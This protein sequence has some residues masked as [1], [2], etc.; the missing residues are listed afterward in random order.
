MRKSEKILALHPTQFAIGML[1]VD[2]K[3]AI[4]EKYSRGELRKWVKENPVPVVISPQGEPFIVD[5]HHFLTVCY[6]LGLKKVKVEVVKDLSR[7]KMSYADFWKWMFKNRSAYPFCQFGE[8]PRKALYLPHDIRGLADDPYRSLAWFVRK[9]G[10]FE[11]SEKN[12]AEFTWANFF[13]QKKLL[14]RYGLRGMPDALLKAAKLAQSSQAKHLPGYGKLNLE[15][16]AEVVA[17]LKEKGRKLKE[18]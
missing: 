8:G 5:H 18:R 11:N 10:A 1:E 7:S 12:F 4:V 15:K 13:R 14:D 3:I 9:A 16:Q 2:E 6:H 17:K